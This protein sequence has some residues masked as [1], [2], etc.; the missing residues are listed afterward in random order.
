[1]HQHKLADGTTFT[2]GIC[3]AEHDERK[4][5]PVTGLTG[6]KVVKG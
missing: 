6:W 2:I 1:M 3:F 4:G 5:K